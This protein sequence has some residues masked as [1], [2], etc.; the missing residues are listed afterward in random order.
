ME[1]WSMKKSELR[2]VWD[3][4]GL[5]HVMKLVE[6]EG[7]RFSL[8]ATTSSGKRYVSDWAHEPS[9]LEAIEGWINGRA[10]FVHIN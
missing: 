2:R 1:K 5:P 3:V 4:R 8:F 10:F 6:A 7:G 9:P